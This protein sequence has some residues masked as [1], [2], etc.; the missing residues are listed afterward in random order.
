[1]HCPSIQRWQEQ[2]L[3][4]R[5]VRD[6]LRKTNSPKKFISNL[7]SEVIPVINDAETSFNVDDTVSRVHG[8]E[9]VENKTRINYTTNQNTAQYSVKDLI[10]SVQVFNYS[11]DMQ[12]LTNNVFRRADAGA[13][14]YT[15]DIVPP[16]K[17]V[18]TRWTSSL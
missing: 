15:G 4:L 17:E 12:H 2:T 16:P 5:S 11:Y 6:K 14:G 13:W 3:S 10:M 9:Q 1:M 18:Q 8:C 7:P